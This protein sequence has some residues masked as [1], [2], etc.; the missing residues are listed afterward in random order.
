MTLI[1]ADTVSTTGY[2]YDLT[3]VDDLQVGAGISV[4]STDTDAVRAFGSGQQVSNRGFI[5]GT[6]DGV[7]VGNGDTSTGNSI[8]NSGVILGVDDAIQSN[9]VGGS[10]VNTGV[11][12]AKWGINVFTSEGVSGAKTTITNAGS[13]SGINTGI[14]HHGDANLTINNSGVIVSTGADA[15]LS[16]GAA[17]AM[18]INN[19]GQITGNILMGGGDDRYDGRGGHVTG[20]VSGQGG[21]DSFYAGSAAEHFFGGLGSD[22]LNFEGAAGVRAALDNSFAGTGAAAGDTY[23]DFEFLFGSNGGNDTLRGDAD[24]NEMFGR[25]GADQMHGAQGN[26]KVHG[27]MGEDVVVGGEGNDNLYG[28]FGTDTLTGSTGTDQ[29]FFTSI[30]TMGDRITDFANTV[31]ADEKFRILDTAI[32]GSG[33]AV[34]ALS[35]SRFVVRN[36]NLAQD[37]NDR[38]IFR[39]TDETLWYDENGNVGGGRV[40]VADLQD[41]ATMAA[42]DIVIYIDVD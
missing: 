5:S 10:I 3:T 38:F 4:I 26:D 7:S 16:I 41:G 13:V 23:S 19:S 6:V 29:Y 11:L 42:A 20:N 18:T 31:G 17:S 32:A 2:A 1:I 40:L 28:G 21:A 15:I 27:G 34:G 33:V 14:L 12:H 30:E 8:V 25:G 39:Q 9:G 37:G 24:K 35:A 22:R 36:D